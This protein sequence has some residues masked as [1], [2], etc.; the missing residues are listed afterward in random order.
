MH[1][2]P[3]KGQNRT[4]AVNQAPYNPLPAHV[5]EPGVLTCCWR[6]SWSERLQVLITGRV[7]HRILTFNKPLQ[8]QLLITIKPTLEHC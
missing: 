3:F 5:D 7:W 8:P 6:L 1:P 4:F 2:I